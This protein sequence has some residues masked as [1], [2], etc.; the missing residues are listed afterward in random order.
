MI[1]TGT[2]IVSRLLSHT[3]DQ[4]TWLLATQS[5]NHRSYT[6]S[7]LLHST[8]DCQA[9]DCTALLVSVPPQRKEEG[10]RLQNSL[11]DHLLI[12]VLQIYC[13]LLQACRIRWSYCIWCCPEPQASTY[14]QESF[15]DCCCWGQS[16]LADRVPFKNLHFPPLTEHNSSTTSMNKR[17]HWSKSSSTMSPRTLAR[18]PTTSAPLYATAQPLCRK[19]TWD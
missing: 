16:K 14:T 12:A 6:R 1:I 3:L 11:K 15:D 7:H 13:Q 10:S 9:A 5:Q 17:H 2:S 8:S 4:L 19:I 18:P